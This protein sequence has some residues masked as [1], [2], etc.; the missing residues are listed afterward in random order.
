MDISNYIPRG[1][2]CIIL[3]EPT[4]IETDSGLLIPEQSR[5]RSREAVVCRVGESVSDL[6]PGDHVLVSPGK[7]TTPVTGID[8][9]S[10]R[11]FFV[12]AADIYCVIRPP[13]A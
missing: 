1:E 7:G 10:D 6:K 5:E 3:R 2:R 9:E 11:Y 12:M 13:K 8:G 4:R